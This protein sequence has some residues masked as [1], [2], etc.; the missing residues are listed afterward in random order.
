MDKQQGEWENVYP[1]QFCRGAQFRF[2]P[3][4]KNQREV[5]QQCGHREAS[6]NFRPV[7]FPVESVQL[8]AEVERPKYERGKAENVKVDSAGSVPAANENEQ[9]DEEIQQADDAK[10]ILGGK[11]LLQIG[12]ASCRERGE[13][14]GGVVTGR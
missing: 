6:H 11:G 14:C 5:K 7:D 3:S 13:R 4:R 1:Q 8:P 2:G 12:R 9:A 10:V